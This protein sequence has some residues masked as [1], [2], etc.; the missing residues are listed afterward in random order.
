MA[1]T[2]M[3]QQKFGQEVQRSKLNEIS[4]VENALLVEILGG[5]KGVDLKRALLQDGIKRYMYG[6]NKM[7]IMLTI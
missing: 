6:T 4:S 7:I 2:N 1:R 5:N 3:C